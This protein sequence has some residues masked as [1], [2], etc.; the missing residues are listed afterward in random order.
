MR[1]A[2]VKQPWCIAWSWESTYYTTQR[3]LL[4]SFYYK[5]MMFSLMCKFKADVFVLPENILTRALHSYK[6]W[7]ES[8]PEALDEINAKTKT[9]SWTEVPWNY[10][11]V[12]FSAGRIVPEPIIR[13]HP[14]TLWIV[15]DPEHS[16]ADFGGT[17]AGVY[18]LAWD[19]TRPSP[20]PYLM[21]HRRLRAINGMAPPDK[22]AIWLPSRHVRPHVGGGEVNPNEHVQPILELA[23]LPVYHPE[24]WNLGRT[25]RAILDGY[26][27]APVKLWKRLASCRYII[28]VKTGTIGQPAL[29]AAGIGAIVITSPDMAYN[30]IAHETCLVNTFEEALDVVRLLE[31]FPEKRK[32]ILEY[33]DHILDTIFWRNPLD[34]LNKAVEAKRCATR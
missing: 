21:D 14:D 9:V 11:D 6:M 34:V 13:A 12:V 32:R 18:D 22:G 33:Q 27:E 29:E 25:Y 26:V 7:R 15:E 23:G 24:I 31:A 30:V 19:Y 8:D 1:V 10:Y 2:F 4:N 16:A 5:T 3:A 28:D 20:T 17:D